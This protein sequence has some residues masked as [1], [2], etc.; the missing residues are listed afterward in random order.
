M[1]FDECPPSGAACEAVAE[2]TARTTRWAARSRDAF[3]RLPALHGHPQWL[4]GIVQGGV[5][6]DLRE[7]SAR[8]LMALDFPGYAVGGLSVGESPSR[9]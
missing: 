2:A 3:E 1:A 7:R 5:H 8:E 9:T 4:F 6:L